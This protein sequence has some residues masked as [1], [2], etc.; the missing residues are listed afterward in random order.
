EPLDVRLGVE[1]DAP[2][3]HSGRAGL[4]RGVEV[5][6]VGLAQHLESGKGGALPHPPPLRTVRA[7]FIAHGSSRLLTTH[8]ASGSFLRSFSTV[9]LLMTVQVYQLPIAGCVR[10]AFTPWDLVMPV[11]F[12]TIH[13]E[14][15]AHPAYPVLGNGQPQVTVG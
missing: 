8:L 5:V 13:E 12:F 7:T 9:V 14:H 6:L 4:R 10:A 3:P 2:T 15:T 1:G 11:E